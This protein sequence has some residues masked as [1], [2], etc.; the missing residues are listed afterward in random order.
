[1][2]VL[3]AALGIGN[4]SHTPPLVLAQD[5]G[6]EIVKKAEQ[7]RFDEAVQ[8]GLQALVNE[9]SDEF[10]YE[11]IADVYLIRAGKEAYQKEQWVLKAV[12]YTE[13]ALSLNSKDKDAGGLHLLQEA[14]SF[15]VAGDF[16]TAKR[17]TYY[18][19]A[20]R[21]LESRVPL[22]Q[23]DQIVVEGKAFPLA[24]LRKENEKRLAEVG[25]KV[26]NAVC[27]VAHS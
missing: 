9:P 14:R 26:A 5:I 2:E 16:G 13:K 4:R 12:F 11:Q 23:G 18:D 22:L 17:C 25:A 10:I 15:E 7:G 27:N 24:P 19:R 20:R 8:V 6:S 21:V 1:M 3:C